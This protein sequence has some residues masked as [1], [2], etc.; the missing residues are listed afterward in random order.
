MIRVLVVCPR[1]NVLC[2]LSIINIRHVLLRL[3]SAPNVF[4]LIQG[5]AKMLVK[6]ALREA[7]RKQ[8]MPYSKLRRI[9]KG[10]RRQFHDDI[11][12]IV[13]FLNHDRVSGEMGLDSRL[14]VRS[15][16]EH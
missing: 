6:A 13:W 5:S 8:E 9:E 15:H 3:L 11:S 16:L 12:V 4:I 7:A 10:V 14:S 2:F 1:Y